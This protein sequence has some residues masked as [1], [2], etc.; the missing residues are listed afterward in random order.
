[1]TYNPPLGHIRQPKA[2]FKRLVVRLLVHHRLPQEIPDSVRSYFLAGVLSEP[3]LREIQAAIAK[4]MV[5]HPHRHGRFVQ[6]R[7]ALQR[8]CGM[9][10]LLLDL[11]LQLKTGR[12][13]LVRAGHQGTE[14]IQVQRSLQRPLGRT[15]FPQYQRQPGGVF[16]RLLV[17][18]E[19]LRLPQT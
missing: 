10:G 2:R 4:Q 13:G 5:A 9:G 17:I 16:E 12:A 7:V 8:F 1:M 14:R 3:S 6:A 19:K 11:L 18:L 15:G